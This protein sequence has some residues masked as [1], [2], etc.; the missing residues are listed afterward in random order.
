MTIHY[1][2]YIPDA[3]MN[4]VQIKVTTAGREY[5]QYCRTLYQQKSMI[6]YDDDISAIVYQPISVYSNI[7]N[8][9]GIFAGINEVNFYFDITANEAPF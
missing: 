7:K 4:G 9:L 1:G 2:S 8:G 6:I 5:D 3:D